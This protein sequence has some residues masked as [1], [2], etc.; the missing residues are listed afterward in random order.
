MGLWNESNA[1]YDDLATLH[2]PEP[3]DTWHPVSHHKLAGLVRDQ[4]PE[5]GLNVIGESYHCAKWD[6][7]N[8]RF[9]K[10]FFACFDIAT[11]IADGVRFQIGLRQG[12]DKM[13]PA[14]IAFGSQVLVCENMCFSGERVLARRHTKNIMADLPRMIEDALRGAEDAKQEQAIAIEVMQGATVSEEEASHRLVQAYR[15]GVVNKTTLADVIDEYASDRH[16]DMHGA[17]T[18]WSIFNAGTQVFKAKQE[19]NM[20][21][22]STDS[23][24]WFSHWRAVSS[25]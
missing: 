25:N 11:E 4:I 9:A 5:H 2:T 13:V 21:E 18:V 22:A 24:R 19:R 3:T 14:A 8:P 16:R 1:T 6:K 23:V 20:V 12:L 15:S 7:D 10:R 17:G